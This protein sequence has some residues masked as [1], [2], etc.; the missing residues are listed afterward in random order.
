MFSQ[1]I[2]DQVYELISETSPI[3]FTQ[4]VANDNWLVP[5]I[6]NSDCVNAL[7]ILKFQNAN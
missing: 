4:D 6:W 5:K 2:T 7:S 1:L 3:P